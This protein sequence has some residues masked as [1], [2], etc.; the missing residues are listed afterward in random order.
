MTSLNNYWVGKLHISHA[1]KI[2][3]KEHRHGLIY[4]VT[5]GHEGCGE[6]YIGETG[7]RLNERIKV[8]KRKR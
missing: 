1:K 5:C 7:R 6:F 4:K 2:T 3:K 8:H